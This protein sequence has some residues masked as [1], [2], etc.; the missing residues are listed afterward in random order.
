MVRQPWRYA[1]PGRLYLVAAGGRV[2]HGALEDAEVKRLAMWCVMKTAFWLGDGVSR[3]MHV[4]GFGFLYPAYN[5]LMLSSHDIDA[6]YG[7]GDWV[8]ATEE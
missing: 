5:W 3:L 1:R 2:L 6:E 8:R 7:F 4:A